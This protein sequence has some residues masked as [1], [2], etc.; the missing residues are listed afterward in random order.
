[1]KN[2]VKHIIID[3]HE[4]IFLGTLKNHETSFMDRAPDDNRLLALF[5]TNNIMD[6]TKAVAFPDKEDAYKYMFQYIKK[7][8]PQ[9]FVAA[10]KDDSLG[11]YVDTVAIVKAGFGEYAWDMIDALPMP[12]QLDH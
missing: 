4:G 10:I 5:S 6:I 8:Y 12:S 2:S 1:M 3:P 11:P 9:A 7:S